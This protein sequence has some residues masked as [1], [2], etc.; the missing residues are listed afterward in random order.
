MSNLKIAG[1]SAPKTESFKAIL[2][3]NITSPEEKKNGSSSYFVLIP[4]REIIGI[5]TIENPRFSYSDEKSTKK[6]TTSSHKKM[7]ESLRESPDRFVQRHS[8]FEVVCDD[9]KIDNPKNFGISTLTLYNASLINGAQSE[10]IINEFY[11]ELKADDLDYSD[12]D[13]HVRVIITVEMN[14]EERLAISEAKN[15][16]LN[17]HD[18]SKMGIRSIYFDEMSKNFVKAKL[19]ELAKSENAPGLPPQRVLQVTRAMMPE[20]LRSAYQIIDLKPQISYSSAGAVL[21]EYKNIVDEERN[22]I[23]THNKF[24]ST[25]VRFYETFAPT[26]WKEY[27]DW[28]SDLDWRQFIKKT[29]N[30]GKLGKYSEKDKKF[31]LAFG[32][33]IPVLYGL[34][35]FIVEDP[36]NNCWNFN[37]SNTFDKQKYM[38]LVF[39]EF[40]AHDFDPQRFGKDRSVYQSLWISTLSNK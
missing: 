17:V 35:N 18:V 40:K 6:A 10:G 26:A 31:E 19:G 7:R 37:I 16:H 15:D 9:L 34:T 8:G 2:V 32:V 3:K 21:K 27:L 5:N 25:L 28:S 36:K 11:K 20:D 13:I 12:Y 22:T 38:S 23:Q 4:I 29:D 39:A 1:Q 33:L 30:S 14:S 24:E